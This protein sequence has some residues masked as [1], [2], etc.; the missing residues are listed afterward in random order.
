MSHLAAGQKLIL[1]GNGREHRTDGL[2]KHLGL[3][4][5]GSLRATQDLTYPNPMQGAGVEIVYSPVGLAGSI[6]CY[7]RSLNQWRDLNLFG[8]NINLTPQEG[9]KVTMPSGT[10]QAL[11]NQFTGTSAWQIPAQNS[12]Y[13]TP[14][15][16]TVT[17]QAGAT[18]RIEATGPTNWSAA[19]ML[20]YMGLGV[21]GGI[22]YPSLW[23]C[24]VPTGGVVCYSMIMYVSGLAA[25]SHRFS[26]WMYMANSGTGG[27]WPNAYQSLF[28]TEQRA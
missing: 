10:A 28:V 11:L 24:T 5:T 23:A 26:V 2:F 14:S 7:D 27:F 22:N 18:H 13:E 20:I 16:I 15:Q 8:K 19:G 6:I 21:D 12:W 9:G 3:M 25:G 17:T 4:D 1:A